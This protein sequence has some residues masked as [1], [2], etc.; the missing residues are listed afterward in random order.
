MN[1]EEDKKIKV[2]GYIRV[3]TEGQVREGESLALQENDIKTYAA[4]HGYQLVGIYRDEG[5]SGGT[6]D[7]P[8]LDQLRKDAKVGKFQKA[9]FTKLTR[10]GRSISDLLE[11]FREFEDDCKVGLVCIKENFDTSTSSGRLH[12]N[13]LAAIAEFERDTIRTQM[14]EGRINKLKRHETFIGRPAYGYRFNVAQKAIEVID[15]EKKVYRDIV[16]LFLNQDMSLNDIAL[17]LNRKGLKSPNVQRWSN[18]SLSYMLKNE[19]YK[20][21]LTIHRYVYKMHGQFS[22]RT[23]KE[24]NQNEWITFPFPPLIDE[25]TWSAIQRKI[26]VNAGLPKSQKYPELFLCAGLITCGVCGSKVSIKNAIQ[27]KDA[28]APHYYA[29]YWSKASAKERETKNKKKC[30]LPSIRMEAVDDHLWARTVNLLTYPEA[31]LKEIIGKKANKKMLFEEKQKIETEIKIN[32]RKIK[33]LIAEFTE[34]EDSDVSAKI[35][36]TIREISKSNQE[37]KDRVNDLEKEIQTIDK[38]EQILKTVDFQ[39][40]RKGVRNCLYSLPGIEKKHI[41]RILISPEDG[42]RIIL[43]PLTRGDEALDDSIFADKNIKASDVIEGQAIA[44]FDFK[45][46]GEKIIG[47]L[48]YLKYKGFLPE[49]NFNG[50]DDTAGLDA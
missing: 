32:D 24:K 40:Y 2:A 31:G 48:N 30:S 19:P 23:S 20:G 25:R 28:D 7:R 5:I 15:E 50:S 35:K 21:T 8:G 14:T 29:C 13:I 10:F 39:K 26:R 27:R 3:S 18:V 33:K 41:I 47:A 44:D 43:R 34:E 16:D 42:G 37:L 6:K 11:L 1:K 9:I 12:R 17:Y 22:K 49:I 46:R 4:A 38:S 36:E 45:V